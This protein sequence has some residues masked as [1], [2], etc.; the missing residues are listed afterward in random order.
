MQW[1]AAARREALAALYHDNGGEE[2]PGAVIQW[3]VRHQNHRDVFILRLV[4]SRRPLAYVTCDSHDPADVAHCLTTRT[5]MAQDLCERN[6]Y[7]VLPEVYERQRMN[8]GS[9]R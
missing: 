5:R 2:E 3:F 8:D 4:S 9:V 1:P 6:G 7:R